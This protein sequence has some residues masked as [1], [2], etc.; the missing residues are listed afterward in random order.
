MK[1]GLYAPNFGNTFG[2]PLLIVEFLKEAEDAGWDGFFLW[3]H[4]FYPGELYPGE[5]KSMVD[6]F[7]TLAAA[8]AKTERIL[9]GTTVTPLPRRRPWKLAKECVTLDHLSNGRFVLGIGLGGSEE[10]GMMNEETDLSKAARMANEHIEVLNNLWSGKEFSYDGEFYKSEKTKC[11]PK[12]IQQPRIKLWGGGM[13]PKKGPLRRAVNLDGIIPLHGSAG[14]PLSIE[15][16]K[17]I[18]EYLK[19]QGELPDSYDIVR[20]YYNMGEDIQTEYDKFKEFREIG[21]TWWLQTVTDWTGDA[22]QI[23]EVIRN[24]PPKI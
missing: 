4:I 12:P 23:R 16:Y 3:D 2:D 7:I 5:S 24:G 21:I 14:R 1:F 10:M 19:L 18:K 15:E 6:P 9:I 13:W 22:K 11:L 17:Q 8:A 20:V